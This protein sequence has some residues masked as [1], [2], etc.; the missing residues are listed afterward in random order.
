MAITHGIHTNKV[1]TS[2]STP[3]EVETGIHFVVGTAPVHT[4]NGK[5]NKPIMLQNYSEAAEQLGY[6]DDWEKYSLCEEIYTAFQL[7]EIS[8]IVVVNVLDPA[9]HRGEAKTTEENVADNQIVLPIETIKDS[10]EI[11]GKTQGEDY[12]TFYT[13]EGCVIEFL[14]DTT[15]KVSVKHTE[16]DPSKV[17]K[18]DMI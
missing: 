10:I 12:D 13:E 2:V 1:A 8:P 14:A 16:V 18:K 5:V 11:T 3:T 15:G 6:S 4:V 9:K 7:Y 17:T